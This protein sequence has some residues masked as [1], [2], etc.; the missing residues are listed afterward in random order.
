MIADF[1]VPLP[2]DVADNLEA[3]VWRHGAQVRLFGILKVAGFKQL[4]VDPGFEISL[5]LYSCQCCF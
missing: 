4:L 2:Q 5:P 1:F 3:L